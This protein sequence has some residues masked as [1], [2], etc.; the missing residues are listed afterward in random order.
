MVSFWKKWP[1]KWLSLMP[2]RKMRSCV[3]FLFFFSLLDEAWILV[4]KGSAA[5]LHVSF[6]TLQLET[7]S[8]WVSQHFTVESLVSFWEI[9]QLGLFSLPFSQSGDTDAGSDWSVCST[10]VAWPIIKRASP[11][12]QPA[13]IDSDNHC[14][15]LCEFKTRP[16]PTLHTSC[17]SFV[18]QY[19]LREMEIMN[20]CTGGQ[21]D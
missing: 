3:F 17:H 16:N 21:N 12:G 7:G 6:K 14:A 1:L 2:V 19:S 15:V 9:G 8:W 18:W 5:L 20:S 11:A 13:L 10:R 4:E